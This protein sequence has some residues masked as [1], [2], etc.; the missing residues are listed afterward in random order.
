MEGQE[1]NRQDLLDLQELDEEA[2]K[3]ES[4]ELLEMHFLTGENAR[5]RRTEGGF[6]AL[7]V[8]EA[9]GEK[10]SETEAGTREYDR[11][12]VYLTFPLTNPEE[13]ISIREADEKAKEIG[14]IEKL[15]QLEKDQQEMLRE[16]IKLRYFRP[17]ITKVLDVKDE[18]GYA[19][20]N[21]VTTFGVCRFTTQMSGDAV[22]HLSDSRLLVTDIDGNRYEIP[23]FYQ[24]GVM[25]RKKLDLFI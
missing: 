24:L 25:E 7:T 5:F 12:G 14:I 8:K 13:F 17:V 22:I 2:L 16:Q 10:H 3:K 11:V 6:V 9:E 23:D 4:E 19:Y 21:V 15:S 20:W 18:Y 1:N